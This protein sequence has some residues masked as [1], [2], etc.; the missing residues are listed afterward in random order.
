MPSRLIGAPVRFVLENRR[1]TFYNSP[2]FNWS[3]FFDVSNSNLV[4]QKRLKTSLLIKITQN[5][6][7]LNIR[8]RSAH[9]FHK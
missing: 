9:V 1:F 5:L 4:L 6:Y 7:V 8:G 2:N 3:Y